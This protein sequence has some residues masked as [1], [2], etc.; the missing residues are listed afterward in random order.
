MSNPTYSS[1]MTLNVN[2]CIGDWATWL[3]H[4]QQNNSPGSYDRQLVLDVRRLVGA[5]LHRS[6]TKESICII[7]FYSP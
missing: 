5:A 7:D 2:A 1:P 6:T 4:L 3:T